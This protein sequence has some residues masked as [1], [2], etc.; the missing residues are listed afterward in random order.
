MAALEVGRLIESNVHARRL[1]SRP[2]ACGLW[3]WWP[4][5]RPVAS[6]ILIAAVSSR[7]GSGS[8]IRVFRQKTCKALPIFTRKYVLLIQDT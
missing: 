4:R 6:M 7:E 5:W 3:T 2:T 1:I 8:R